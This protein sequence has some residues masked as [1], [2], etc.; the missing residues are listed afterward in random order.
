MSATRDDETMQDALDRAREHGGADT[1]GDTSD[2]ATGMP[3]DSGD[4][5]GDSPSYG[6]VEAP[7]SQPPD[8]AP[9][10][11][12]PPDFNA[13]PSAQTSAATPDVKAQRLKALEEATRLAAA[14]VDTGI[15]DKDIAAAQGRDRQQRGKDAF[16]EAIQAWLQR[17]PIRFQNPTEGEDLTKRRQLAEGSALRQRGQQLSVQEQLAKAFTEPK[18]A[19]GGLSAYQQLEL[20]RQRQQDAGKARAAQDKKDAEA[21]A[22]TNSRKA[23][24]EQLKKLGIDPEHASQKDIDRVIEQNKADAS[25]GLAKAQFGENREQHIATDA[26]GLAKELGDPAAF[27]SKYDRLMQ[28]KES[29]GGE[30]P[31]LGVVEGVRQQPGFVGSAARAVSP[32]SG[33]AIEGRKLMRQLA[34]EYARSISGAGVSD[35]ERAQLNAAALDV[36]N[37]DSRIAMAGLDT[38]KDMY[39]SKVAMAKAGARPEAVRRVE[40]APKPA[41]RP[42][43]P[44]TPEK[45]PAGAI[46]PNAKNVRQLKSGAWAYT[47]P[48][49]TEEAY[50][51]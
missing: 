5:G 44:P 22:L 39:E 23:F 4:A 33:Q 7:P 26:A 35:K 11:P 24:S 41:G 14:P 27:Q 3:D 16:T 18:A 51:P 25:L 45:P 9:A 40:S 20:E 10:P 42:P 15:G 32:P 34:A 12:G 17:R 36:E 30:I 6:P 43:P 13:F 47:L 19:G 37:D 21:G 31:G 28:L 46:P 49:G 29:N 1:L 2:L 48:D 50:E 38:L 8:V